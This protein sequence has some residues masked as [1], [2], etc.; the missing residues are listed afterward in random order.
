MSKNVQKPNAG[1]NFVSNLGVHL[2]LIGRLMLDRRVNFFLKLIP[3]ASLAYLINPVDLPTP[4]DDIGV[5]WLGLT[6][7]EELCP[8]AVVEEHLNNIKNV[9][10]VTGRDPV[11][12]ADDQTIDAEFRKIPPDQE[13]ADEPNTYP[14]QSR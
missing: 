3:L 6:V 11:S 8:P 12:P 9:V 13:D 2:R 4:L 10:N 5:V 1:G 14:P 7:F